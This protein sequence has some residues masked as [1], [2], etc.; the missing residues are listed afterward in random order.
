MPSWAQEGLPGDC[1]Q[2]IANCTSSA[3]PG[4]IQQQCCPV[5]TE[6]ISNEKECFCGVNVLAL[7]N[8]TIA[9]TISDLLT[10]CSFNSSFDTLCPVKF[11]EAPC[12]KQI[13][14]CIGGNVNRSESEP[15]FDP[16][17][18]LFNATELL[19]CSMMQQTARIE[20]QCFCSINT[21]IQ[22]NPSFAENTTDILSV[23]SI[24]GSVD[25][26]SG[27]CEESLAPSPA[28]APAPL[29]T[30]QGS[31]ESLKAASPITERSKSS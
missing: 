4:E 26:L 30:T 1:W 13:N 5:I 18:P 11:Q 24:A 22:E 8:D 20:K 10:L 19:C 14:D 28:P 25:S 9:E 31:V 3:S 16:S 29:L 15:K 2:R 21:F 12:W 23:C 17:S 6:E 7:Q 27:I